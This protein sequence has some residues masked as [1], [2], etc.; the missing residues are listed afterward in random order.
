MRLLELEPTLVRIT[1]PGYYLEVDRLADAQGLHFDCPK[2]REHRVWVWFRDRAV[3]SEE[4]PGPARWVVSGLGFVDLTL[5]PSILLLSGCR[6][7]GFVTLG[8]VTH[9]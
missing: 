4:Q 2:C 6:W 8:Q 5:A 9:V 7:H 3:P 1:S